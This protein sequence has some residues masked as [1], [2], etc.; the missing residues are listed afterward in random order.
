VAKKLKIPVVLSIHDFYY[1]CPSIHLLNKNHEYCNLICNKDDWTCGCIK[2]IKNSSLKNIICV[3][4]KES[5]NFLN[6]CSIIITPSQSAADF[7]KNQYPTI[8]T[9]IKTIEHGR[10]LPNRANY[11]SPPKKDNKI[12]ILF[13]GYIGMHKGSLLIKNLKKLDK[14]NKLEFH[15]MGTSYPS[16]KAYGKNHGRYFRDDFGKFVRNINPSF[17]GIFS[18][19]PETYSHTLTESW[20]CG[21]PVLATNLGALKERITMTGGGWLVDYHSP[22]KIYKKIMDIVENPEEYKE[23]VNNISKIKFKSKKEMANE[24]KEIYDNLTF[25]QGEF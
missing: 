5:Y 13:P 15:F 25:N 16:L 21:V 11:S 14:K 7:Y 4:R 10:D 8:K 2:P 6:N 3:W 9:H 18:T 20:N 22:K 17:I 19:I 23:V 12:K 1:I 24:Y